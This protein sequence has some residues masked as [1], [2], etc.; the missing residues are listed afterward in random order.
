[1]FSVGSTFEKELFVVSTEENCLVNFLVFV[2]K[3][4]NTIHVYFEKHMLIFSGLEFDF[5]LIKNNNNNKT[6]TLTGLRWSCAATSDQDRGGH[7]SPPLGATSLFIF[8][9][10]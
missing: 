1:M 8:Y 6:A 10:F 3:E 2:F 4:T 9:F 5:L 7:P